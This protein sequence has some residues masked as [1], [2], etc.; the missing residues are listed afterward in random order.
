MITLRMGSRDPHV[1]FLQRLLNNAL[2]HDRTV[3]VLDEDGAF[4]QL[5]LT[6]VYRFQN[7]YSGPMGRLNP[8]GVVGPATWRALGLTVEVSHNL[9]MVGQMTGMSCWVVS[10]GLAT[11]RLA[12]V[13]PGQA[14]YDPT[15]GGLHPNLDNL[16]QWATSL[17]MYLVHQPPQTIEPLE[18]MIRRGPVILVG[19]WISGGFHAVVISGYFSGPI[20]YT[21]MI[22]VNNSLPLGRGSVELSDYP[23][24]MLGNQ[25]MT[26]YA[27]LTR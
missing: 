4:G 25:G 8:D 19:K 27:L 20:P 23:S 3:P 7:T 26:P 12:S 1:V 2:V 9:P 13:I 5:T 24:I 16:Q 10:G 15:D 17:N 21:R 14:S 22:R 18:P 11:G 6:N